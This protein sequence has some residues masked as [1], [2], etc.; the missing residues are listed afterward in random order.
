MSVAVSKV[1]EVI[2][3]VKKFVLQRVGEFER[4]GREGKTHFDFRPFLDIDY[5]AGLFSE[6]CFCILTA[7]SSASMGIRIQAKVRDEGFM[8]MSFEELATL[9]RSHG[10][11]FP[12]QRAQRIVEVRQRWKDIEGLLRSEKDSKEIRKLLAD[13]KSPYKIKGFGYKE[14]SHFLRNIGSKDIAIIDRH[15]Y[16]FLTENGLFPQVKTLTP[17]RYLEAE[18]ALEKVCNELNITQA[19][20]DLYIFYIKTKKVLK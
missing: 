18:E 5:E 4:L 19:E 15:V 13:P 2:P 7:N 10:H 14:A 20:L 9:I 11:R 8:E 16:R 12:E 6:L 17:K 1:E 3:K